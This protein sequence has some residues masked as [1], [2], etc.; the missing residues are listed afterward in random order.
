M[1][2]DFRSAGELH[3][4]YA[5]GELSPVEELDRALARTEEL[6]PVLNAMSRMDTDTAREQARQ[7]EQRWR[8]GNARG[9]LDGVPITVKDNVPVAGRIARAGSRGT[10]DTPGTVNGPVVDRLLE[11]GAVI[12]GA[13][14]MPDWGCKGVGDSPLWGTTRNPWDRSLT[15]GGSSSGAAAGVAAGMTPWSI[16]S[17]GAGSIRM[18]AGFCGLAGI[19]PTYGRVAMLP[20][21]AF[22]SLSHQGP[23]ARTVADLAVLLD[24]IAKPDDRDG[25][26]WPGPGFQASSGDDSLDGLRVAVDVDWGPYPAAPEL[27]A[28]VQQTADLLAARG[29]RV[30][31]VPVDVS[32]ARGTL[33]LLWETGCAAVIEHAGPDKRELFDETMRY[34]ADRAA[35]HTAVQYADA[36]AAR[37]L[38]A[39]RFAALHRDWDV[40]LTPVT[41][42]PAFE[43]DTD[44]PA[45][46]GMESWLDWAPYTYPFNLTGQPAMTVP[47]GVDE[48]NRPLAIQLVG[49]RFADQRLLDV[50]AVIEAETGGF[51]RLSDDGRRL[52]LEGR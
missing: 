14:T 27:R 49:P 46:S 23:L 4:A 34:F 44:I 31:Q 22:G 40:L 41:T 2:E 50:A 42:T 25:M 7:A 38:L 48:R 37:T 20:G 36:M 26:S 47:A 17:D 3:R 29:A 33:D 10:P 6:Q 43:V 18:P 12:V 35:G 11:A 5:T 24:T 8:E 16:G 32:G 1:S 15:P 45:G 13:T 30:Q 21:S 39:G 52:D 9:P 51:A 28:A 19:K